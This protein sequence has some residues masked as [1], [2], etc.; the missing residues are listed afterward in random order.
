MGA[1]I[2]VDGNVAKIT[3]VQKLHGNFVTAYDLR[4]GA[5]LIIGGLKAQGVTIIDN[6]EILDRGYDKIEEKLKNIG[7]NIKRVL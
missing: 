5:G 1:K 7:A 4:A 6:A 3:G 2:Q